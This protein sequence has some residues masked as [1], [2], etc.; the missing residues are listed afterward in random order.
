VHG[1]VHEHGGHIT[2]ESRPGEGAT[3]QVLFPPVAE[4]GVAFEARRASPMRRRVRNRLRGHVLVVDDEV[5]VGEFMAELLTGWGLQVTLQHNAVKARELMSHN[6][7]AF[8]L[9]LL[10]Q[11]MPK[12]TGLELAAELSTTCPQVP[13]ILYT[14]YSESLSS[15]QLDRAHVRALV[16][17]PI[18]PDALLHLLRS[19]LPAKG[20]TLKRKTA[21][22][23]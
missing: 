15:E 11:T 13:V 9:I 8:D 14:G 10:D 16:R 3:F 1:I 5:A 12:L 2:V 6:A 22:A 20:N 19:H 4:P 17:K 21:S 7:A 23:S 18:E